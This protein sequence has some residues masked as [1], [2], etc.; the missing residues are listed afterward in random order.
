MNDTR[1]KL[2]NE[3]IDKIE[4]ALT[5]LQQARDEERDYFDNMPENMQSGEKGEKAQEDA[6]TLETACDEIESACDS[7][8]NVTG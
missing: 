8:R 4:A 1:R 3:A 7:A 2:I 6:D 5:D